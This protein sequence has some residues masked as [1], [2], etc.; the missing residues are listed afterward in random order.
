MTNKSEILQIDGKY[1]DF[2]D[3][4]VQVIRKSTKSWLHNYFFLFVVDGNWT[5]WG[6][7]ETCSVSCGGGIQ[8]RTRECDGP[9][10]GGLPCE[11]INLLQQECNTQPC[12]SKSSLCVNPFYL[13]ESIIHEI[14]QHSNGKVEKGQHWQTVRLYQI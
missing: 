7:W 9:Y 3:Y 6:S 1:T 8:N 13:Y 10:Y 11:G 4:D 5:Q 12:P 2:E 14:F